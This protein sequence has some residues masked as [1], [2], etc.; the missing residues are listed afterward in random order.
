MEW[1]KLVDTQKK[2]LFR[3]TLLKFPAKYP[4]EETVVM[5]IC[6]YKDGGDDWP[7]CLVTITGHRAGVSPYQA[8]PSVCNQGKESI[9]LSTAWLIENWSNWVWPDGEINDVLVRD[10]L[11]ASE[12]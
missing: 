9:A 4:F 1:T 12:I 5:M 6:E 7:Y 8:L 3:G 11:G 10:S 2:F